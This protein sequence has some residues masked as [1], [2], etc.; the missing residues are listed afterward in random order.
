MAQQGKHMDRFEKLMEEFQNKCKSNKDFQNA[1][2]N[3]AKAHNL[4]LP[5][6]ITYD[7]GIDFFD[8][9][10]DDKPVLIVCLPPVSNYNVRETEHTRK[11]LKTTHETADVELAVAV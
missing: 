6:N 1:I 8:V 10:V 4:V 2:S 5:D 3:Y 9:R 7:G 11:L